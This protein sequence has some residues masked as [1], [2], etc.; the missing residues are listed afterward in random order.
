[1][2]GISGASNKRTMRRRALAELVAERG[3]LSA[4]ELAQELGVSIMTIHRD[5][6]DLEHQGVVRKF[7][8]GVSAQ[9]SVVFESNVNFRQDAMEK[10]KIALAKAA[11]QFIEPGMSIMLDNSTTVLQLVPLLADVTPLHVASNFLRAISQLSVIPDIRLVTLGGDYDATSD[12]FHG[13]LTQQAIESIRVDAAF[14]S[15]SAISGGAAYQRQSR[16]VSF[17]QSMMN[18]ASQRYL[19]VDHTKL[20]KVAFHKLALLTDF[21]MVIID[22]AAPE[23]ALD[24]LTRAGVKFIVAPSKS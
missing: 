5:L 7:R 22:D 1:M 20:N 24:E 18:A 2:D 17:K 12:T 19:L 21:D 9:P 16:I 13:V 14:F 23:T 3:S 6:E 10:E 8:G 4:Q 11:I 15:A